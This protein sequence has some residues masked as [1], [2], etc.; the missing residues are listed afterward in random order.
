MKKPLICFYVILSVLLFGCKQKTA[1]PQQETGTSKNT[2]VGG[3]C[4][5]CEA[6][7]ESPVPF[8]QLNETDTLPGFNE[9]GQRLLVEGI[10]YKRDGKTPAPGVVL[11]VYHTGTNGL[12]ESR[13]GDSGWAKRHGYHR[14]WVKTNERGEFRFYTIKPAPYPDARIPA[15]IHPTVKEPVLNEYYIDEFVFD[16]DPLL[17]KSERDKMENR[18]GNGILKTTMV[19]GMLV[20]KRNI[21]LGLNIPHYPK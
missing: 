3:G 4:E 1:Q 19:N 15:H 10:I 8:D 6:V 18:G 14:G 16:D 20:A 7:F 17:V 12:Y 2:F 11:Y 5:G 13:N 9:H 21:I